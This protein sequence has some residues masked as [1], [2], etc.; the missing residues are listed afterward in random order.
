MRKRAGAGEAF[1][2]VVGKGLRSREFGQRS[3]IAANVIGV[4]EFQ[5]RI[6]QG[7]RPMRHFRE[8]ARARL[9]GEIGLETIGEQQTRRP[10]GGVVAL[11]D[12]LAARFYNERKRSRKF[13]F[14][15]FVDISSEKCFTHRFIMFVI[16]FG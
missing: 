6:A 9:E 2:L 5:Q 16:T 15:T 3:E 13:A 4:I 12:L 8:T 11:R 10:P 1:D 14:G 7:P